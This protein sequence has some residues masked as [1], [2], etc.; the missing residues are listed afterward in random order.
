MARQGFTYSGI[1][2]FGAFFC[3]TCFAGWGLG[4]T[5]CYFTGTTWWCI[6]LC[7]LFDELYCM[8]ELCWLKCEFYYFIFW[9][10]CFIFDLDCWTSEQPLGRKWT[11]VR[12]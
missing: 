5:I 8:T 12:A 6:S 7:G 11:R 3:W 9:R 1:Y 4:I 2:S 10:F